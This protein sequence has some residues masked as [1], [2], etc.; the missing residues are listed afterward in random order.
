L[1][2]ASDDGRSPDDQQ[3]VL[4][5]ELERCE[6]DLAKRPR[7]AVGSRADIATDDS[8]VRSGRPVISALTGEGIP[9]LLGQLAGLVDEARASQP[10]PRRLVVHRPMPAGVVVERAAD[11]SL[12]VRGRQAE[13]AVALS[14]LTDAG[15]LEYAQSRLRQ[16]GVDR[17]LARAGAR[18]GDKVR[19]GRF[20]FDWEPD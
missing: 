7:L 5:S 3:R 2:L 10:R 20:E 6:P 16:L 8:W 17:A 15:A 1:D 11:G 14:D 18:Q 12:V 19:I 9:W 13:R 4:L